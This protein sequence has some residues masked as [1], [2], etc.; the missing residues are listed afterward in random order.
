MLNNASWLEIG[1]SL[2]SALAM[3]LHLWLSIQAYLDWHATQRAEARGDLEPWREISAGWYLIG[4][5]CL[6]IPRLFDL[7]VG[8]LA[9][10]IPEPRNGEV[11][12]AETWAQGTLI[13]SEW[14]GAAGAI[15]FWM[16]R[17][18]LNQATP[19]HDD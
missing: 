10:T 14:I 5:L 2:A 16:A 15:A 7:G 12:A 8:I 13:A 18:V 6:F 9:M 19:N 1:W 3:A 11:A 17:R 4:Q